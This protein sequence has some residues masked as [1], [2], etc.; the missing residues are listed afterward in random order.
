[1]DGD[2]CEIFM[3]SSYSL[4]DKLN[5]LFDNLLN[6]MH[7]ICNSFL[8]SALVLEWDEPCQLMWLSELCSCR[9]FL[10]CSSSFSY[11]VLF[12]Q[13]VYGVNVEIKFLQN[14]LPLFHSLAAVHMPGNLFQPFPQHNILVSFFWKHNNNKT[15]EQL[16]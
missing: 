6:F 13:A 1:M 4:F 15:V 12:F 8:C 9:S 10:V 16:I 11:N 3:H 5:R 7:E 2:I 14:T